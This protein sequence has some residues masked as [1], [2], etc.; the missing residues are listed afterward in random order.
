MNRAR[1]HESYSPL[2]PP[3]ELSLP[4]VPLPSALPAFVIKLAMALRTFFQRCADAVV[5]AEIAVFDR[6]WGTAITTMVGAAARHRIADLLGDGALTAGELAQQTGTHA[7]VMQRMLRALA[8]QGIFAVDPE[9]RFTNTRL[10]RGLRGGRLMRVREFL[11]YFTSGSNLAAWR[12]FDRSL[13]DGE[14]AFDRVHQQSVWSWFDSHPD[15]R[16]MFAHAM[17]G[18]T[19]GDAPFVA[20]LYPFTEVSRLCDVG[21]GR[22]MLMSELLL[23]FP[24][25]RG[26][27]VDGEGVIA[28]ARQLLAMR[29]VIERVELKAGSFFDAELP[30]DCDAYSLKNVLHDWGDQACTRIL[31]NVRR[32]MSSDARLLVIEVITEPNVGTGFGPLLDVQMLVACS[33]GRE[34]GVEETR[35]LLGGAGFRLARVVPGP[36]VSVLEARPV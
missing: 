9:G 31:K 13:S 33:G 8:T 4:S 16:E 18:I 22:G 15:E 35:R 1:S 5:P 30:R 10:S 3:S 20:S 21:G 23:R 27:L 34:R 14:S 17:M 7:D 11:T 12:D 2:P 6:A 29:G 36:T 26:V 28:S 19:V 24:H 25:L 32:A